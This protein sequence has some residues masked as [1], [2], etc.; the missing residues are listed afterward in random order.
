MAKLKKERSI[1]GLK[2]F[3]V[4]SLVN[5]KSNPQDDLLVELS[6]RLSVEEQ[7]RLAV[8]MEE[9]L[10]LYLPYTQEQIKEFIAILEDENVCSRTP[11]GIIYSRR[12]AKDYYKRVV[13]Y[14]NGSKGGNPGVK[15]TAKKAPTA[16]GKAKGGAESVLDEPPL[17]GSLVNQNLNQDSNLGVGKLPNHFLEYESN[18]IVGTN[19]TIG[20]VGRGIKEGGVGGTIKGA[21]GEEEAQDP[22]GKL[23]DLYLKPWAELDGKK[24]YAQISERDFQ[25][26]REFVDLIDGT[27]EYRELY[28]AKFIAPID[29]TTVVRKH[30]FTRDKWKPVVEKLLATGIDP[31]H[32]LFFRIPQF[33]G[34]LYPKKGSNTGS[35]LHTGGGGFENQDQW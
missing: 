18:P 21:E 11:T 20:E 3:Q 15:G 23:R 30:A 9:K 31:K 7:L 8:N 17:V 29:F 25:L 24:G 35:N 22:L 26:W 1:A 12:M 10:H 27:P 4:E 28:R 33:I 13:A 6:L 14:R 16:G 5:Q 34:Y 32:N 2:N 19:G